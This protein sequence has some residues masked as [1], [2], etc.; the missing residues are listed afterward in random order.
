MTSAQQDQVMAIGALGGSGTRAV[1]QLLINAGVYMGEP[2]N[3]ANDNIFFTACFMNPAWQG[4]ATSTE[5][6]GRIEIFERHMRQRNVSKH[7]LK[8]LERLPYST[9]YQYPPH[10]FPD[11]RK[12]RP[13]KAALSTW[14]WKEPN[15]HIYLKDLANYFPQLKYIHVLRHGLDMAFAK[16]KKQ[17]LNWGHLFGI[18]VHKND[19]EAELSRK[20]LDYWISSTKRVIEIGKK[21]L[22]GRFY[23]LKYE[24]VCKHSA[25]EVPELLKFMNI[26]IQEDHSNLHDVFQ[27]SDGTGRYKLNDLSIFRPEQLKAVEE[28]G[29]EI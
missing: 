6:S 12:Q 4:N 13:F 3:F 20:Q 28:L 27:L 7:E 15:T 2:L 8:T 25:T 10:L 23:L 29:F 26:N 19:S 18:T 24:Q 5:I 17:L 11:L 21:Y 1:A 16:N 22:P 14:G 9:S